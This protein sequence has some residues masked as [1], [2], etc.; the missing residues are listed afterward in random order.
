MRQFTISILVFIACFTTYGQ[1]KVNPN[2]KFFN[3]NGIKIYYEDTG[4]GEPLL[5]LHN[6]YGTADQW[7]PYVGAYSKQFRT[8]SIDMLGH[9]RS[10]I[11]KKGA[12]FFK[13]GDYA[14]VV[15]ALM[16]ALKLDKVNAIGGSSGGMTL[17]HLNIMQPDRLKSVIAIGA[18]IYFS[19]YTREWLTKRGQDSANVKFMEWATEQHGAEKAMALARQFWQNLNLYGDPSFTPDI[20]STIKAKWLVVQGDNDEAVPLQQALEMHQYIPNSRLWIVPNGGHLPH[21]EPAY[22]AEFSRVSLEFLN[23]K[24]DKKD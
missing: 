21:L 10:D 23:G 2:G 6:F 16:D 1:V 4:N 8:I 22:H 14:K 7:K 11:Y 20:L 13:H 9:G 5:L 15:L 24:W 17:L 18:Q 19:K 12:I 3:Y